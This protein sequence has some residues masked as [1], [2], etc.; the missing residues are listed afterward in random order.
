MNKQAE[1]KVERTICHKAKTE[2]DEALFVEQRMN[3]IA[4]KVMS[5]CDN[6]VVLIVCARL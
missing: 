2:C 1:C 3:E 6:G 4:A 5:Q